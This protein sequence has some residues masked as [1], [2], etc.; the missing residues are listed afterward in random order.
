MAM[1]GSGGMFWETGRI[2]ESGAREVWRQESLDAGE[3]R[4]RIATMQSFARRGRGRL[5]GP[6][7]ASGTQLIYPARSLIV[8]VA[9]SQYCFLPVQ[10]DCV[11]IMFATE[12]ANPSCTVQ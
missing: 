5:F 2:H 3:G 11:A 1:L 9:A 8:S 10:Y 4:V 7:A 12:C 6:A